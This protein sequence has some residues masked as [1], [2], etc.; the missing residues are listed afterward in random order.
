[1]CWVISP[2]SVLAIAVSLILSR[3]EVFPWSTFPADYHR[4]NQCP[5]MTT[6]GERIL[7]PI[8]IT[9]TLASLLVIRATASMPLLYMARLCF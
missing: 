3:S 2:G 9:H 8:S 1:M 5:S 6:I 4:G 7:F